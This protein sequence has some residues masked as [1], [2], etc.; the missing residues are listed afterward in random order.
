[1]RERT[2][3]ELVNLMRGAPYG[4][5]TQQLKDMAIAHW[6]NYLPKYVRRL[7]KQNRLQDVATRAAERTQA[8][9]KELMEIGYQLH[10]AEEVVLPRYILLR[11]EPEITAEMEN[12]NI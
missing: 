9:I 3:Q 11:E 10:E 4:K 1:M 8:E 12:P 2:T 7:A 6:A 5:T